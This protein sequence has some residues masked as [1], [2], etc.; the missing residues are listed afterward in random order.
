MLALVEWLE[1]SKDLRAR[2]L[3]DIEE[4]KH[5]FL[6]F[7]PTIKYMPVKASPWTAGALLLT[8][9][10]GFYVGVITFSD[11]ERY[12]EKFGASALYAGAGAYMAEI[13]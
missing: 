7:L 6:S 2:I 10:V 5:E 3:D 4:K 12:A 8:I 1:P 11:E 9:L 13:F